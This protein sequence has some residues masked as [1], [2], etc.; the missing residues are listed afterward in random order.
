MRRLNPKTTLAAGG[1]W[2]TIR[3]GQTF[4][5]AD[6]RRFIWSVDGVTVIY[7]VGN[8]FYGQNSA[9]FLGDIRTGPAPIGAHRAAFMGKVAEVEMKLLM[10]IAAGASGQLFAAVV[11]TEILGF[12]IENQD[13]FK[14]WIDQFYAVLQARKIL[15]K[16]APVLYDKLFNAILKQIFAE[17]KREFPEAV[18][19]EVVAFGVGVI[20]GTLGKKIAIGRFTLLGVLFVVFEQFVIRSLSVA[21]EVLKLSKEKY[22]EE[23]VANLRQSKINLHESEVKQIIEEIQRHPQ[24]VRQALEAMKAAFKSE[25]KNVQPVHP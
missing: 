15:K 22:T 20:I 7:S 16:N 11:G 21:P 18:S 8:I 10:G 12:A 19:H 4:I 2:G 3:A 24:E 14:T 17:Y 5:A 9:G 6:G 23:I 25:S 13:N 1:M